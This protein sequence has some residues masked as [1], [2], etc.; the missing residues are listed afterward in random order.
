MNNF[1]NI[2]NI[3]LYSLLRDVLRRLWI[4][5]VV[6]CIGTMI[7]YTY[8]LETYTPIYT[9]TAIYV[10]TPSQGEGT[11]QSNSGF[12]DS[13]IGVFENVLYSDIMRNRIEKEVCNLG[14]VADRRVELIEKTNMI[15]LIVSSPDPV[16][17][18]RIIKVTMENYEG[19]SSYLYSGAVLD[20]LKG[21]QVSKNPDNALTPERK[22]IQAGLIAAFV[23]LLIIGFLSLI[24]KTVKKE[25]V[26]EE[27]LETTLLGTIY[28]EEKNRTLKSKVVHSVKALLITSP[29]INGKFIEAINNIRMKIEY[30]RDRKPDNNVFLVTS[31]CENEGKSTVALNIALS[32]VKE[33]KKIIVIDADMRKPAIYKMLDIPEKEVTDMIKLLQGKCGLDEVLYHDNSVDIDLIMSTEGHINTNEFMKSMAM[34]ELIKKCSLLADYVIIDTPPMAMVS[35]AEALLDWVDHVMLVVRQDFSYMSDI[36]NCISIIENSNSSLMGCILNDYKMFKFKFNN[37]YNYGYGYNGID[38]KIA[39]EEVKENGNR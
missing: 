33:K 7:T 39:G 25:A 34:K 12:A 11:V 18:F 29:I 35:D 19:L 23:A 5:F 28:H 9:S 6:G 15:K 21:P 14:L 32:L 10:V 8:L 27:E 30:E 37:P 3:D 22:S 16:W 1:I 17:S 2:K 31:V 24:R 26:I 38:S 4:V 20:E 13:V 36:E